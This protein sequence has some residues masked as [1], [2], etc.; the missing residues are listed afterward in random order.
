MDHTQGQKEQHCVMAFR[1]KSAD[2]KASTKKR[3]H[4]IAIKLLIHLRSIGYDSYMYLKELKDVFCDR[5]YLFL[6]KQSEL[7][8]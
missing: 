6:I 4:K 3:R 8:I 2:K 1:Q 5:E 7:P